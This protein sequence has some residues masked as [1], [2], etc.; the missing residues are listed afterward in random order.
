M[1]MIKTIP[2]AIS[3][4]TLLVTTGC[5]SKS[6][7]GTTLD[8][9]A[10]DGNI[11]GATVCIDVN[12]NGTCDNGED[13]TTTDV[14]GYF[15]LSSQ[16]T[17]SLV[18]IGGTDMGTGK[19][20]TG[21]FKA[22]AGST[23]IS[24]LTSMVQALVENGSSATQAETTL[25]KALNLPNT[26]KL[27]SFDPFVKIDSNDA[28]TTADAKKV[29]AAQAQIQTLVHASSATVAGADANTTVA[30]AMHS[31]TTSLATSLQEAVTIAELTDANTTVVISPAI[32]TKATKA[33]ANKVYK[34]NTSAKVAVT[35]IAYS[36]SIDSV[37]TA[38]VTKTNI[39]KATTAN[40]ALAFNTGMV[41]TNT[42]L[43]DKV[44]T[45]AKDAATDTKNM[46]LG[47]LQ[48]I[49]KVQ[50]SQ[51]EAV[52]KTAA[53]DKAAAEAAKKAAD[54]KALA[55][56]KTATKA[57]IVA[58]EEA[59]VAE[60]KA[61]EKAAQA[62]A[63]QAAAAQ[64]AAKK[65]AAIAAAQAAA[66]EKEKQAAL[67]K[68]AAEAAAKEAA[69]KEAAAIKA[70]AD[71]QAAKDAA[72]AKAAAAQAAKNAEKNIADAK[73]AAQAAQNAAK[74]AAA[75]QAADAK[76]AAEAA[77]AQA[78]QD[79]KNAEIAAKKESDCKANNGTWNTQEGS[80]SYQPVPTG[81]VS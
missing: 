51:E 34:D 9:T 37:T 22:P 50:K 57:Q 1:K 13:N 77:Q 38:D 44:K 18:L 74:Q 60:H 5:S 25:K 17:G 32:V 39:E 2:L 79:A 55:N 16:Q 28:N 70:A 65:E 52:T 31:V 63:A 21:T 47:T 53:A 48:D 26:L 49:E 14:N 30:D 67:E 68:A 62:A 11:N 64:A 35:A 15:S 42:T 78:E 33:A 71:A 76:A 61:A 72:A 36:A 54:A 3:I 45:V 8:G 12:A 58:A 23:V 56:L 46:D 4:V 20:F 73:A 43:Q 69:A 59:K 41:I 27:T 80:C 81:G 19:P 6:S 66:A 29:L 24:P 7:S 75:K 40:T 10:F